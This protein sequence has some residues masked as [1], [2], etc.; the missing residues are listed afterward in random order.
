M[1]SGRP[2]LIFDVEE[3]KFAITSLHVDAPSHEKQK[4]QVQVESFL[5]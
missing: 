1:M 4:K 2:D 5:Q 3:K